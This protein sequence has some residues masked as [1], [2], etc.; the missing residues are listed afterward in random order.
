M[1]RTGRQKPVARRGNLIVISAPSG[2]GK[3]TLVRRLLASVRG[4]RFSISHT[5]RPPRPGEREGHDYFFVAEAR[6]KRMIARGEFAEWAQVFGHFYGTSWRQL[7]ARQSAG[8]DVL[9]DIDVQG[10]QKL[11]PKLSETVSVFILPPSFSVLEDRLRRRRK[12]PPWEIARRLETSRREVRHWREY[13]YL[14]VNDDENRAA[15]AL[16]SVVLAARFRRAARKE[17][18]RKVL[19]TFGG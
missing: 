2:A 17:Q 1:N 3:T 9:L 10:W 6:F 11:K 15:T 8:V 19:K 12:D 13:D 7:R 14:I 18:A 16:R 5:T 4:I